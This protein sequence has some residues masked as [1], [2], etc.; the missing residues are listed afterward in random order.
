LGRRRGFSLYDIEQF[1][2]EAGCE[3]INEGAVVTL[4]KEME[5]T[6]KELVEE[7]EIYA[8]YAGRRKLIKRSDIE[9]VKTRGSSR[10]H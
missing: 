9:L 1:L 3:R 10:P 4:E 2:K 6:V 8:N 7:A 5:D